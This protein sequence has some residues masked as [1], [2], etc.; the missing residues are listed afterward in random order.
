[1]NKRNFEKKEFL[2][3]YKKEPFHLKQVELQSLSFSDHLRFISGRENKKPKRIEKKNIR[4]YW[5]IN[6]D[7]TI[8]IYYSATTG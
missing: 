2:Q 4:N 5:P 6:N 3:L 8:E 1:M 7:N